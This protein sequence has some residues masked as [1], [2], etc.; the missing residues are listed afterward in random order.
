MSKIRDAAGAQPGP[1]PES[2]K[3]LS[4][5]IGQADEEEIHTPLTEL[6]NGKAGPQPELVNFRILRSLRQIMQAVDLHSRHLTS[7]YSITGPQL[8]CLLAIAER[9]PLTLS[10]LAQAIYLRSSTVVG[11]VDR[12][13]RE[14]FVKRER[15]KLDRRVVFIDITEQGRKFVEKAPSPIQDQLEDRLQSLSLDEQLQIAASLEK[16]AELMGAER[17]DAAPLLQTGDIADPSDQ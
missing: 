9:G 14:A 16:V 1:V 5:A 11:I 4:S 13:E 10:E 7:V 17:I 2:G 3:S 6:I 12:L 8:V 15:G